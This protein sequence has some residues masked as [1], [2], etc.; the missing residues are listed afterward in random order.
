MRSSYRLICPIKNPCKERVPHCKSEEHFLLTRISQPVIIPNRTH[1]G[2][3]TSPPEQLP[4]REI[5]DIPYFAFGTFPEI[6]PKK[7]ALFGYVMGF[8]DFQTYHIYETGR[9]IKLAFAIIHIFVVFTEMGH[10]PLR[11]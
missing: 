10:V 11:K 7:I 8:A 4:E 1:K 9:T 6:I 3:N 5:P 2:K